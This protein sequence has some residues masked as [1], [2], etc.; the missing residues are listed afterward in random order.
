MSKHIENIRAERA[1][2]IEVEGYD[3]AHDDTHTDGSLLWVAVLY[4]LNAKGKLSMRKD[5]MAPVGFP[6]DSKYWKPKSPRE[7]LIRAGALCLAEKDRKKRLGFTFN[8]VEQKLSFIIA[9]LETL[10]KLENLGV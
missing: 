8:H 6:W 5:G 3:A 4:Y 1:R 9:S 10:D 7:D 2:Q